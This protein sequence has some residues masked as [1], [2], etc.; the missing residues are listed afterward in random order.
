MY[1][2][3]R[4]F[5]RK[6][7]ILKYV[8]LRQHSH[9][10]RKDSLETRAVYIEICMLCWNLVNGPEHRGS[11]L[12]NKAWT[13]GNKLLQIYLHAILDKVEA[14]IL[15][16]IK[17]WNRKRIV[18]QQGSFN[19]NIPDTNGSSA[20]QYVHLQDWSLYFKIYPGRI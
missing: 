9:S 15:Q 14:D 4:C 13:K 6:T 17:E 5:V 10:K 18:L 11:F 19:R 8:T 16:I 1:Y 7:L 20:P 3:R 2:K 12:D